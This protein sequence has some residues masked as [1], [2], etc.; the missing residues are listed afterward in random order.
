MEFSDIGQLRPARRAADLGK[1]CR[2]RPREATL[3]RPNLLNDMDFI[4]EHGALP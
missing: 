4:F 1:I 2:F 3:F